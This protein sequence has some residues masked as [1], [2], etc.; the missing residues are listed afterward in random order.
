M[1]GGRGRGLDVCDGRCRG[2]LDV[3]DGGL[4]VGR[5]GDRL[6]VD[7]GEIFLKK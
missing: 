3:R 4:V 6:V 1:V 2:G 5:G 7:W